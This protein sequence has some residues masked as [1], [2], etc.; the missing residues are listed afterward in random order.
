MLWL[1][2][3]IAW[4]QVKLGID[5]MHVFRICRNCPSHTATRSIST[6]RR[7]QVVF[8]LILQGNMQLL[9]FYVKGKIFY[10]KEVKKTRAVTQYH[11]KP[12]Q[13]SVNINQL[14]N[15]QIR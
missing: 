11:M 8:S 13:S 1:I 4:S 6:T 14:Q 7:A 12:F 5:V 15:V 2:K 3:V 10:G 9:F